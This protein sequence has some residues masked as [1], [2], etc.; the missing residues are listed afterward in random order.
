MNHQ[1][2]TQV[3]GKELLFEKDKNGCWS[4]RYQ[5]SFCEMKVQGWWRTLEKAQKAAR[6]H[7]I[8]NE[9]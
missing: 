6:E 3:E 9:S 7:I 5:G 1:R 8:W 4:Y 2:W